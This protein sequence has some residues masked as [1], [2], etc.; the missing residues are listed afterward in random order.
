VICTPS[1]PAGAAPRRPRAIWRLAVLCAG[2]LALAG[3]KRTDEAELRRI[4]GGWVSLGETVSFKATMGCA[5]GLFELVSPRVASRMRVAGSV[6]EAAIILR[7]HDQVAIIAPRLT[8]DVALLRL[9]DADRPAGMQMRMAGLEG[10]TC[11]DGAAEA[12]FGA[13][14]VSP[15][16]VLLM[17]RDTGVLALLDPQK[18]LLVAVM[19]TE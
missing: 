7:T 9:I 4:L 13:A 5:A 6:R 8:P 10:R 12:A 11:M 18:R 1:I 15:A 16:T 14:L 2:I 3:C 17:D 19:G